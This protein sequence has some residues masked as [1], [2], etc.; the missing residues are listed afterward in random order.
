M[1]DGVILGTGKGNEDWNC[2]APHGAG[3]I[4]SRQTITSTYT[5]SQFKKAMKGIYST[6]I[7]KGSLDEAPFAYRRVDYIKEAVKDTVAIEKLLAPV[8]NYKG[9]VDR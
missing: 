4:G 5:V 7:G 3:R 2:S 9:G 1:R 8:Y 6:C